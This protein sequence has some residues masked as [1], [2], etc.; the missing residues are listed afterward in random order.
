MQALWIGAR[1]L[2]LC[3]GAHLIGASYMTSGELLAFLVYMRKLFNQ[4]SVSI[5]YL[6][7]I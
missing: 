6:I 4:F 2:T 1:A 5:F 3:Y 7:V